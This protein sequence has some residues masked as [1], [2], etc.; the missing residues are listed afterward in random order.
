MAHRHAGRRHSLD[1]PWMVR[2][3][4]G[5]PGWAIVATGVVLAAVAVFAALAPD[6]PAPPTVAPTVAV[7]DQGASR[8]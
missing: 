1:K 4:A 3:H 2:D 6:T 7:L 5:A 8:D